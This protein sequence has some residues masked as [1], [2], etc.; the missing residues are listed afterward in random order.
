MSLAA[1][2]GSSYQQAGYLHN[3]L[4]TLKAEASS[5]PAIFLPLEK[6]EYRSLQK[7]NVRPWSHWPEV[8]SSAFWAS[9]VLA[10][11]SFC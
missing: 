9:H 7:P 8:I 5:L 6:A 11:V 3:A 1:K 4:Y 2:Q 10:C